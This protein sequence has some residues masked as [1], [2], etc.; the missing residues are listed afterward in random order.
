MSRYIG[1]NGCGNDT[2]GSTAAIFM[3]HM[4]GFG[5]KNEILETLFVI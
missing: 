1:R 2:S 5:N 4:Q 3:Q